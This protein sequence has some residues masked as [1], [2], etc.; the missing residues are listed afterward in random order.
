MCTVEVKM[1]CRPENSVQGKQQ[2]TVRLQLCALLLLLTRE[3]AVH[4]NTMCAGGLYCSSI[5]W[6][7]GT[8]STAAAKEKSVFRR[9][10]TGER[11]SILQG[12]T[13]RMKYGA[14]TRGSGSI[15]DRFFIDPPAGSARPT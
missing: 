2:L 12:G 15:S 1:V 9:V 10:I 11:R 3:P 6:V 7:L 5:G 4:E 8:L 14:S 13:Y